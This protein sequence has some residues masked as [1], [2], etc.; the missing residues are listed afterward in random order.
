MEH[1]NEEREINQVSW[2]L[3]FLVSG[4]SF[5]VFSFIMKFLVG[6]QNMMMFWGGCISL[7][8]SLLL[9][10]GTRRAKSSVPFSKEED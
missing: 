4:L 7:L 9:F 10:L 3:L 6:K 5:I 2:P 1:S 8:L